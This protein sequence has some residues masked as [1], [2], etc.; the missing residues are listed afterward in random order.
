MSDVIERAKPKNGLTPEVHLESILYKFITLYDQWKEQKEESED[1][2][3]ELA[4]LIE[5]FSSK[6]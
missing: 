1:Q 4:D 3:V 6:I 2:S 5:K